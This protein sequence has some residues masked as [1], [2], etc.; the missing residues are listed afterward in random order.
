MYKNC[1]NWLIKKL[2]CTNKR[3]D[4]VWCSPMRQK[5]HFNKH[6]MMKKR[7]SLSINSEFG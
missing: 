1:Y 3:T 4:N 7:G 2:F 5:M 6:S